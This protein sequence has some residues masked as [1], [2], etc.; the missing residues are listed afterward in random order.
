MNALG[1]YVLMLSAQSASGGHYTP[2]QAE[3]GRALYAEACAACHGPELSDGPASP[4]V[5]PGFAARWN[6]GASVSDLFGWGGASV[7]DLFFVIRTTMPPGGI[8]SLSS[9][10]YLDVVAYL[11]M[12]N[13][14]APGGR[15]LVEREALLRSIP[16]EWRGTAE[17]AAT[18]PPDFIPGESGMRPKDESHLPATLLKEAGQN[19][20]DWLYHTHDYS[21]RRYVDLAQIDSTNASELRVA[22]AY[23]VGEPSS[24]QTGPIVYEGTM[25]LTTTRTTLAIDAAT[26]RPR[27]RHRWEPKLSEV[28]RNNRGVA[29]ANGRV[30]RGTSD[31][32]LLALDAL[33]GALLWARR[34]ADAAVGETFTM[35]PLIYE[36]RIFIGPA[37]SENAISG[38]VGA[39]RLEDGEPIWRFKTVPGA[40]EPG[41]PSWGNPKDIVLGGGAVW[42]PFSL[43]AERG[44][45]YVAVTNP[46]PDLP[47]SLRPGDNLYTNSVVALDVRTG[48]LLWYE[49]LVPSDFHDWDLTQV[50]PLYRA[51]IAGRERSLMA[52]AGKDG[53]LRVLDRETRERWFEAE[54]TTRENVET[55]LTPEGVRA[56]P[57]VLGGVEWNGP[58]YNERTGM[59]YIPAVD[60][61]TTFHIAE[62]VR[63]IPGKVYM[64]GYTRMEGS[65][66]G[67]LTAIDGSD[68]SIEWR[69]DSPR[70][71]LSGVTTTAGGLVLAGELTG[72]FL[73]LEASSGR[74]LYRFNTGGPI[75][76]GIVSYAVKGKQYVAVMSGRP[77]PLF[78]GS[79]AGSPT[80]FVFAIP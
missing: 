59:L 15:E 73:V 29:V 60:W 69:Y 62:E 58:A 4:L 53:L 30:V 2:A 63:F 57:G 70:P 19:P 49:Q 65:G 71:M 13:G 50:S 75:G 39:F 43:D 1:L 17:L 28:W 8:G 7:D 22:C 32:Y 11:L 34:V 72:D 35:A 44:E 18:A 79:D 48:A 45:L 47:A 21:G 80:A 6:P 26:C 54:L 67:R 25:Y 37:G 16:I 41:D 12:R 66:K 40:R 14:Y 64:G 36:D 68:G 76:G 61:C 42:T 78:T 33:D 51:P 24:F 23:Q 52:T 38:W 20:R 46:A 10:Q 55:P 56:C 74:E 9:Q 5:G 31:G 77:S 3:R 27:W